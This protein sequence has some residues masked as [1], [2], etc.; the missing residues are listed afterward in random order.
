ME[1]WIPALWERQVGGLEGK[2][3]KPRDFSISKERKTPNPR[4][5]SIFK[6][7]KPKILQGLEFF[8]CTGRI[9]EKRK[10]G[11]NILEFWDETSLQVKERIGSNPKIS[12]PVDI[13]LLNLQNSWQNSRCE[14]AELR[15][16]AGGKGRH[17]R[18]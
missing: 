8:C 7:L 11:C 1:F 10:E 12:R 2:T 14:V 4:N 6:V 5:I 16:E 15:M 9:P 3:P 13:R 17:G 18:T